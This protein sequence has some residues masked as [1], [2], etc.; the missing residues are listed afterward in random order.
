MMNCF[1][2]CQIAHISTPM[3]I[4]AKKNNAYPFVLGQAVRWLPCHSLN[5]AQDNKCLD[6][7]DQ[8]SILTIGRGGS[9]RS[10]LVF[11]PTNTSWRRSLPR[12]LL[13]HG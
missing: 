9:S 11:D 2:S 3:P 10:I 1:A 13:G 8:L 7:P 12:M 5:L 6:A 4:P